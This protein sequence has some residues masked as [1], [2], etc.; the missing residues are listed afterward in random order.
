MP[1]PVDR[2]PPEGGNAATV[3]FVGL[4]HIGEPMAANVALGYPL[5]AYDLAPQAGANLADAPRAQDLEEL[6]R[7][8]DLVL[9]SLPT[10]EASWQVVQDL[11][12]VRAPRARMIVEL[13]TIGPTWAERCH[14][15]AR[16]AGWRY[17]DAPV[18]GGRAG[19]I[20]G[21]LSTMVA[22]ADEDLSRALPVLRQFASS[23]FVIG[24]RA[25]L[26]QVMK[27]TNNAI[28]LA[29]LPVTSEA[30][31]FG[32]SYGLELDAMVNVINASS[33]RTQR[34]EVMFPTSIVTGRYDHGAVGE[35]THKD[36]ALYVAEA[37]RTGTPAPIGTVVS[38]LYGSFVK[39]HPRTDYSYLH[40]FLKGSCAEK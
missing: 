31:H 15:H 36:L 5:V 27:L 34:S 24:D 11:A 20:A 1:S 25:G 28:A 23:V 35:I 37:R 10:G 26:G 21:T 32:A 30:L 14:G 22:G 33:G 2:L 17:V 38:E 19:A 13:S 8:C 7:G 18:S 3:G 40:E 16:A 9:L 4:G 29:V 6:A 39:A 12:T